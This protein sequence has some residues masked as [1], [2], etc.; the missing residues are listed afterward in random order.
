MGSGG[1]NRA[2][3][4]AT[5]LWHQLGQVAEEENNGLMLS[6]TREELDRVPASMKVDMALAL[7]GCR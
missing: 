2:F 6:F 1:E 3:S 5:S 4:L 7:T